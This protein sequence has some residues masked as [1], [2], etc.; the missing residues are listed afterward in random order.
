MGL[1]THYLVIRGALLEGPLPWIFGSPEYI[2]ANCVT[3]ASRK[4]QSHVSLSISEGSL[5]GTVPHK[6][7]ITFLQK[8]LPCSSL[9]PF[10]NTCIILNKS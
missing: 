5:A 4:I 3:K 1:Y 6:L 2:S 10:S 8:W 9:A 7:V